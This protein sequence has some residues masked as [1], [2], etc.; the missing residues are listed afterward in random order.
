MG[1]IQ[2]ATPPF[3][4]QPLVWSVAGVA[5]VLALLITMMKKSKN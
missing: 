5:V 3:Y 4:M 1:K 2:L